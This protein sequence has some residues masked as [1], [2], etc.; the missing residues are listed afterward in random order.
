[1]KAIE[2]SRPGGPDVL[3]ACV[4]PDPVPGAGELLIA[5][6]ASGVNRPDVLQRKGLYPMPPGVSDLPGLEIAGTVAAGNAQE[7]AAA[8]LRIGER[9]CALVAGGGYAQQCVAPIGQVLPVP[10]G[11]TDIEAA[12]LPETF[13]TVWQNVFD[14][15]RLQPGESLLVQGGSSGIGVTAIQLAK[16]FGCDVIATAGSDD[17]CEACVQWGA[18]H[19][20]N[21]RAQDFVAEV[22]RLTGGR[23]VDVVLDMVAG[24][25]IGRELQCVADDGRIAVIAVQGGT[26]S[27]IDAGLLLRKRVAITGSTL[28]PRPLAYKARLARELRERVW[29]LIEAGR[30]KPAIYRVFDAEHAAQAHALMESS[31]HIGKIVLRW[32]E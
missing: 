12:S 6:S 25:Y 11:L 14:I 5:V 15:A 9:V 29:P 13:F 2:I 22:N 16:A 7:L 3:R 4:R 1:M 20:I 21:Y 32:K 17:K 31:T 30:I 8:G 19:A 24:E 10:A 26:S 28:R 27:A 23:G 18:D